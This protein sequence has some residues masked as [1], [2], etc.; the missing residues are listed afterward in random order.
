MLELF[1]WEVGMTAWA[2]IALIAAAVIIG[3]VLQYVGDVT[4]GY[5]WSVAGRA[6]IV[7]GWLGSEALGGLS[8]WGVEWEG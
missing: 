5:E 4:N 7:G 2:V 1:G 8:T 3:I 6:A